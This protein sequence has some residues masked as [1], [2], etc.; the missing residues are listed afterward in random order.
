MF[1]EKSQPAYP[2]YSGL[3]TRLRTFV[4]VTCSF[5]G[6]ERETERELSGPRINNAPVASGRRTQMGRRSSQVAAA[7]DPP[8]YF[9]STRTGIERSISRPFDDTSP[10][11]DPRS[12]ASS[13]IFFP[14]LILS[15]SLCREILF[16][17]KISRD[18]RCFPRFPSN[19]PAIIPLNNRVCT[20]FLF[21]RIQIRE[22]KRSGGKRIGSNLR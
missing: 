9:I 8:A 2:V 10:F 15:L 4:R 11:E 21:T 16:S 17:R 6:G 19:S 14:F 12:T 7:S 5:R 22:V 1:A 20:R 18:S 13:R 3:M